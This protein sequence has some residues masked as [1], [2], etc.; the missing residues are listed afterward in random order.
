[1]SRPHLAYA[2]DEEQAAEPAT[3]VPCLA[4]L[5]DPPP[6]PDPGPEPARSEPSL[7]VRRGPLLAVCG[8]CG[9][10]GASTLAYLVAL[11]AARERS[12]PVLVA[13]TGG[14]GGG[15]AYYTG[16]AAPYSLPEIA[17]SLAAGL[18]PGRPY[19]TASEGLRVLA[20]GPRFAPGC[21]RAG[22]ELVLDDARAA[23]SLTVVDCGTLTREA[24][25]IVLTRA[26]Q[27]AWVLP[28]TR[29]GV[30]RARRMLEAINPC[31]LGRELVVARR[32]ERE[33]KAGLADLKRIASERHAPLILVPHLPDLDRG[34][35]VDALET[36]QVSLQAIHGALRR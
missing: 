25:Q 17:E 31:L 10:A 14:T 22:V 29:S 1:M 34:N 7:Q 15:L 6:E 12:E 16:V 30:R 9:G 36:A 21:A 2:A 26:S 19:V 5:S 13:D 32:D 8:C 11:A 18:P 24:D 35:T 3:P 27:V 28:A 4:V 23:H 20:T 33:A